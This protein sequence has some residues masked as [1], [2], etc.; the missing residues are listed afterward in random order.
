MNWYPVRTAK[1]KKGKVHL[2]LY[3][4]S[5][6]TYCGLHETRP[7]LARPGQKIYTF[8][9]VQEQ[10]TCKTCIKLF[11]QEQEAYGGAGQRRW[12]QQ[13]GRAPCPFCG[14]RDTQLFVDESLE[15][16]WGGIQCAKCDAVGPMVRTDGTC[17][18]WAKWVEEAEEAWNTR[19]W[20]KEEREKEEA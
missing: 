15:H 2:R 19:E 9:S 3:D 6:W 17:D 4:R 16:K 14:H 5:S 11:R 18:P 20:D 13:S 8:E 1:T 12:W 7:W 10:P